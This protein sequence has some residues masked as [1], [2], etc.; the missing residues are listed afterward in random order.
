MKEKVTPPPPTY[1]TP[2]QTMHICYKLHASNHVTFF[3]KNAL[4]IQ[5][6]QTLPN[7]HIKI[8]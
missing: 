2:I 4:R 3:D 7:K 6:A 8:E 1:K 5:K